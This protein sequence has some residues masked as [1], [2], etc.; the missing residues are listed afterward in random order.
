MK[1]AV[2]F[3]GGKDSAF[4]LWCAQMQGWDVVTLVTLLP[5]SENSWMFHYPAVKWTKLQAQ[6][7]EIAQTTLPTTGEKEEELE[8]LRA[9]L[10]KLRKSAGIDA[11]VSGA[12][13]SEYQRTRLDN[14]CEILGLKSFAPLWHKNQEQLV[15]EQIE[16][17]FEIIL[18]ACSALGL[19]ANWLGRK[20]GKPEL[21]ELVKLNRRYGLNVAFEGGE[22]ETFVLGGPMFK[23]RL[24]VTR[25]TPRWRGDSGHLDL[26][27]VLLENEIKAS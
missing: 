16:A 9:G 26:E 4:A 14:M 24:S 22:A 23:R 21:D 6:A 20:L 27:E 13:A 19:D 18:T 2:L 25:S 12:I 5:D 7:I 11:I 8:D 17:G 10:E 3:S 15:R 1:V